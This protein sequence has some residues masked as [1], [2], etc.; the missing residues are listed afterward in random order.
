MPDLGIIAQLDMSEPGASRVENRTPLGHAG[1]IRHRIRR[2]LSASM[3]YEDYLAEITLQRYLDPAWLV[4]SPG[5]PDESFD[6]GQ[7][8][9]IAAES[10]ETSLLFYPASPNG[11]LANERPWLRVRKQGESIEV[12]V[13]KPALDPTFQPELPV[14]EV[15]DEE[16]SVAWLRVAAVSRNEGSARLDFLHSPLDAGRA[17][18][19]IFLRRKGQA[20]LLLRSIPYVVPENFDARRVKLAGHRAM[21]TKASDQ[22]PPQWSRV[23]RNFDAIHG[24]KPGSPEVTE[25]VS[26]S[27]LEARMSSGDKGISLYQPTRI[28][29]DKEFWPRGKREKPDSPSHY[30]SHVAM[31]VSENVETLGAEIEHP[32][33]AHLVCGNGILAEGK[34]DPSRANYVRLMEF[35]VVAVIKGHV[36][37]V[38]ADVLPDIYQ[39]PRFDLTAIGFDRARQV[40]T[41]LSLC[42]RITADRA[43]RLALKGLSLDLAPDFEP[44]EVARVEP[45]AG[46]FKVDLGWTRNP[47]YPIAEILMDLHVMVDGTVRGG[48]ARCI[49]DNGSTTDANSTSTPERLFP[50]FDAPKDDRSQGL[51]VTE[52]QPKFEHGDHTIWLEIG[53][54]GSGAGQGFQGSVHFDWFFGA[55]EAHANEAVE[56]EGLRAMLE[57]QAQLTRFTAPIPVL[58][59]G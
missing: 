13:A 51:A 41:V 12:L 23:S 5:A 46:E 39:R 22:T 16:N 3:D 58:S 37:G 47:D 27:M 25:A 24:A 17:V 40:T 29:P 1:L 2:Q 28:G 7:A 11:A 33:F 14:A 8:Q 35:E 50:R 49:F 55:G 59:N 9:W 15:P 19:S 44:L 53:L 48:P 43:A 42:I 18:L 52:A 20:P 56:L 21:P 57:A 34:L 36:A 26:V 6:F 10:E 54:L 4:G 38:P 45:L 32:H 31:L 30:Q